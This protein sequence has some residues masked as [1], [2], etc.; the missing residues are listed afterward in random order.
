MPNEMNL[1]MKSS[2][3]CGIDLHSSN[4]VYVITDL[5][6]K[7]V[8]KKRLPNDLS[9]ILVTLEP[10]RKQLV[11]VVVESTYNW[12]WLVDGLMEAVFPVKLAN[13]AAIDQYDGIKQADDLNDAAFLARLA[14]TE[15]LADRLHLSQRRKACP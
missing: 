4:A 10:F 13:P 15:Y 6:D 9:V 5:S 8:L 14:R 1:N 12:Y 11:T 7:V 3:Y 2:L